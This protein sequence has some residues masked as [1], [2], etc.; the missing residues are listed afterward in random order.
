[1]IIERRR[2]LEEFRNLGDWVAII[3]RRK[4]GKS[5]F[6]KKWVDFENY[7]FVTKEGR[8]LENGSMKV[9]LE[10]LRDRLIRGEV[11]VIDE[12]QRLGMDFLDFLHA[13]SG[14]GRLILISSTLWL[15]RRA[16]SKE[17]GILGLVYEFPL[18]LIDERDLLAEMGKHMNGKELIEACTY[19]QEPILLRFYSGG[20]FVKFLSKFLAANSNT[21]MR[22][23][24]EI[25]EEEFEVDIPD[26]AAE[27]ITT[28]QSAVDFITEAKA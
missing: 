21:L 14:E 25:F 18:G 2:E 7:Y 5:F 6:V 26:E 1:M 4:T 19:L 11:A 3:G 16:F 28:V 10:I 9:S 24:G 27:I 13:F 17:S 8:I 23:V 22:L 12:F 20:N 15:S